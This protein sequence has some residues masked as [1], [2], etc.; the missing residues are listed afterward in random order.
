MKTGVALALVALSAVCVAAQ[1]GVTQP[2]SPNAAR[3]LRGAID[4]HVHSDPDRVP[5][6]LDAMEA[7]KQAREA[8]L[9][10]LVLKSHWD[11]TA[12]LAMLTRKYNPGIEVFGGIDLNLPV[13]GMNV[14]AVRSAHSQGSPTGLPRPALLQLASSLPRVR[15]VSVRGS[16]FKVQRFG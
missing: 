5:R 2:V 1:S 10:G 6:V 8:G 7:V 11:P 3:D 9:R 13:G 16:S 15:T 4:I 12:G 14:A